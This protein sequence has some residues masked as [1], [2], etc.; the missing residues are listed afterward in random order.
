MLRRYISLIFF[1]IFCLLSNA[2]ELSPKMVF[3]IGTFV[4]QG[5]DPTMLFR[6]WVVG[7]KFNSPLSSEEFGRVEY[8]NIEVF[9][10][11]GTSLY[12]N[13]L[14]DSDVRVTSTYFTGSGAKSGVYTAYLNFT[15]QGKL[16][17][18]KESVEVNLEEALTVPSIQIAGISTNSFRVSWEQVH[19]SQLYEVELV[20]PS[21]GR[22]G[23]TLFL[24]RV[25]EN[26]FEFNNDDFTWFTFEMNKS[27][28]IVVT[29]LSRTDDDD[30]SGQLHC[31]EQIV[32][33]KLSV[34]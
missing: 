6:F 34:E 32:N 16:Q 31:S 15:H 21:A 29:A 10:P 1:A 24:R 5:N 28:Q 13:Y 22:Y 2:Q 27:Y 18:F 11:D 14:D 25:Q 26:S 19:G 20:D 9:A 4:E 12:K 33:F 23:D 7:G 3:Q 30:T 17:Q 8:G